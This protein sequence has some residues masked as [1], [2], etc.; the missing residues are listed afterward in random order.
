MIPAQI[1][2]DINQE[3]I[4]KYIKEQ[5]DQQLRHEFLFVDVNK[6]AD[7]M[8]VSKRWLEEHLLDD[9]RVMVCMRQK[10][11]KRLYLY[12]DVVEAIK[13]ISDEW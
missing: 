12:P 3:E 10:N 11:R 9:P 1:Q 6:L 4:Q 5:L 7:M 13:R 8:S 2:V